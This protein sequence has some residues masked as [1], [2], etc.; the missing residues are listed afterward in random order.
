[1]A[2][3]V[4]RLL[5]MYRVSA[6]NLTRN[7]L[8]FLVTESGGLA[9]TSVERRLLAHL[10]SVDGESQSAYWC[11]GLLSTAIVASLSRAPNCP[12]PDPSIQAG[13]PDGHRTAIL[14]SSCIQVQ[15]RVVSPCISLCH[16]ESAISEACCSIF[17]ASQRDFRFRMQASAELAHPRNP[18][19]DLRR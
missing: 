14:C 7:A 2:V 8:T 4:F 16:T 15:R 18:R 5:P 11:E 17:V 10:V 19:R 12:E 6:F 3:P 9:A 13:L 1:M